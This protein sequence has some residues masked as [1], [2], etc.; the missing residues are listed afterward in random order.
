MRNQGLHQR[1]F[2]VE[3][4][5]VSDMH[6]DMSRPPFRVKP[7]EKVGEVLRQLRTE[8]ILAKGTNRLCN[9]K[10]QNKRIVHSESRGFRVFENSPKKFEKN[11]HCVFVVFF[12][13]IN[14][15]LIFFLS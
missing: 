2:R 9:V 13:F 1:S 12:F 10:S 8:W 11:W 15:F 3:I 6:P 14:I 7:F 5:C 4:C